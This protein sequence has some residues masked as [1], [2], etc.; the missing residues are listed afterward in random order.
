MAAWY[1]IASFYHIY[2]LGLCGCPHAN[3]EG[4]ALEQL[5]RWSAEQGKPCPPAPFERLSRWAEHA[6]DLGLGAIYIGPLFESATHGY[7]TTDFRMVDRRLGTNDDFRAWVDLCHG[8]GISVVVDGVF[9]HTG[10][11]F[12]AF[13][14][15][16][17]HKWDSWARE[18]Y[19][20]VNFD[21]AGP[22]GD[23]FGYESWHGVDILPA[24]NLANQ[25]V[26]DYLLDVAQFWLE[27]FHIDGIR[28]D[29]ADVLDFGF[30]EQLHG[31]MKAL[32]S[33][34]WLMG[35]VIHGDYGRWVGTGGEG[36]GVLDSVTN[37]ELSKAMWSAHNSHNYFEMAHDVQRLFG[38]W[39]LCK[40]ARLYTFCDN[41][42]VDRVASRLT[43]QR[44]LEP[45]Y[46][47]LFTVLGIPSVY[48]GSEFGIEGRKGQGE[49]GDD[50]LRPALELAELEAAAPHP[51]LPGLIRELTAAKA[52]HPELSFGEYRELVL[53][54]ETYAFGRVLG[55]G[56]PENAAGRDLACVTALNNADGER[57]LWAP[58]P[59]GAASAARLAGTG[60]GA[61]EGDRLHVRLPAHAGALFELR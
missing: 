22:M 11:G 57:E 32:R 25:D 35:E 2:P 10:R 54:N 38:P 1:D 51:E 23:G 29:S 12:F 17:E 3:G 40:G 52:S 6:A 58:L 48:Y 61:I 36:S 60:E 24:L 20:G 31:R 49:R 5:E 15:L 42:D 55:A 41:Q 27:D 56:H 39:G 14:D 13:R 19:K 53:Q 16:Q 30:M 8:L 59:A 21:W 44:D 45:L 26:K 7:D 28:L 18:W 50:A 33:D 4:D 34:F 9:N 43:D 47:F 37:Y 46:V